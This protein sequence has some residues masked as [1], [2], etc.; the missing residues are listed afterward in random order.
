MWVEASCRSALLCLCASRSSGPGT[1]TVRG[2]RGWQGMLTSPLWCQNTKSGGAGLC[3]T[4]HVRRNC[5]PLFMYTTGPSTIFADE[6]VIAGH[7]DQITRHS[8]F[9]MPTH[10]L[11]SVVR[12]GS[13]SVVPKLGKCTHR[14]LFASRI[15]S[16][17][18]SPLS[19]PNEQ[20]G[21]ARRT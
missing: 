16:A 7:S 1:E 9:P 6:T 11:Q 4:R 10:G 13:A 21:T 20:L 2:S 19:C 5:D 18:P 15:V 17:V 12:P 14:H 3:F 8:R